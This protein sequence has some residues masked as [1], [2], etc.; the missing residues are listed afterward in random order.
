[1]RVGETAVY[2]M[3]RGNTRGWTVHLSYY[4]YS[5]YESL[6]HCVLLHRLKVVSKRLMLLSPSLPCSICEKLTTL[7]F[8]LY[9]SY[10]E[11]SRLM[12]DRYLASP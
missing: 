1:M 8:S 6:P 9:W 7:T 3:G 5:I 4:Y 10:G 2:Q 12:L 11:F